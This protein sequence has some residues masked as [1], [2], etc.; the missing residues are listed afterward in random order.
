MPNN[1]ST[2]GYLLPASSPAPLEGQS[3]EDFLQQIFVGLTGLAG[4][5]VR[6]RWQ[7]DPPD[8]P[9]RS[10]DWFAFGIMDW[11]PDT[12]AVEIH[13]P[14]G[15]GVSN[16]QRHETVNILISFYGPNASNYMA[17]LRDGLQIAQNREVFQLNAMGLV[18]TGRAMN[19][20][21]LVKEKWLNRIDL[22][23]TMRRLILRTY[24]I[25]NLASFQG[26]LHNEE[27]DTPINVTP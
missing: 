17:T 12:Y 26:T 20:P 7:P 10:Q 9:A 13:D 16:L 11:D 15:D 4:Q 19:V 25:L 21:S 5:F 24:P 8:L 14:T 27:Y 3:F 18:Q 22:T 6:P 1:S 23:M 2:G